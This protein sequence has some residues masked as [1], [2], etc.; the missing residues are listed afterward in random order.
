MSEDSPKKETGKLAVVLVR[1][2]VNVSGPIKDTLAM[3]RIT[4]KNTCVVLEGSAIVQGMLRKVKDY[5]TWGPISDELFKELVDKRGQEFKARLEDQKKKYS[6]KAVDINGKKF[7]PSFRL[8]PP[9]KGFGRKGI[10]VSFKAGGAL[11]DRGDKMADLI[12]RM[13]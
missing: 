3:L 9:R 5:V 6:Y 13:I 8:N 7:K 10:K 11:G 1:G 4:R 2:L 12:M